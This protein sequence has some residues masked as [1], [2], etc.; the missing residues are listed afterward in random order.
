MPALDWKP[1]L[2]QWSR[3]WIESGAYTSDNQV[4]PPEVLASG[5]LGYPGATEAQLVGAESRLGIRL[6]PSYRSFLRTTNGW[7]M[8]SPFIYKLWST[9]DIDWHGAKHPD[10]S[11]RDALE[12]VSPGES[13]R[14]G[15]GDLCEFY[16]T[17]AQRRAALVR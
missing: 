9:E 4:F 7:R 13:P 8:T 10:W 11:W 5:W 15:D 3:A 14:R 6:P 12:E 16:A 1:F 17:D 2:T